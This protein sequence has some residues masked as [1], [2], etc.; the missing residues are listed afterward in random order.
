MTHDRSLLVLGWPEVRSALA[1][2]CRT[3]AGARA[4]EE[5]ILLVDPAEIRLAYQGVRELWELEL[6]GL[7]CPVGGVTDIGLD[8]EKAGRGLT[9]E[10]AD[11]RGIGG[12]LEALSV[13]RRWAESVAEEAPQVMMLAH[14]IEVDAELLARLHRSFDSQGELCGKEYPLLED[15]RR[16]KEALRARIRGTLDELLRDDGLGAMLQERF[17]TERNG[18]FVLPVKSSFRKGLGIVHG[19]SQSGETVYV[20]PG[21]VVELH[22]DLTEAEHALYR[23]E[24]R[25]LGELSDRVG[26][27]RGPI[28]RSLE[29]ATRLDLVCARVT[30]GRRIAGSLPAVQSEGILVVKDARHPLLALTPGGDTPRPAVGND[31]TLT[32]QHTGLILTG[33]NAGGKTVA[34][35]TLGLL[36]LLVRAAIPVP[37]AEGARIDVF[38]P[39]LADIGDQQSVAEGLSTFSAHV[40]A[41]SEAIA[42]ARPGAL[43]LIDEITAGTDPGQGAAIARAVVEALVDRGARVAVTTH[44]PELKALGAE[45]P[46]FV[47]AAAQFVNGQPTFRLETG[48]PGAS[49][50][51][52]I[53]RRMGMPEAVLDRAAMVMDES[54]RALARRLEALDG[55]RTAAREQADALKAERAGL[56]QRIDGVAAR[57]AVLSRR[58]EAAIDEERVRARARFREK[59]EEVRALV[60][61]LQANPEM[62]AANEA[63]RRV[64]DAAANLGDEAKAPEPVAIPTVAF[65]TGQRVRHARLG[66]VD[67]VEANGEKV[68]VSLKGMLSWVGA[69]DLAALG[70]VENRKEGRK[71][72]AVERSPKGEPPRPRD[73]GDGTSGVHVPVGPNTID[74]RGYRVEDAF[75][76]I[77]SFFDGHAARTSV[78][79]LLHGH[80]TGALKQGVR[81]WLPSSRYVRDFRPANAEEGGDAFTVVRLV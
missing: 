11:L 15:L 2:S 26:R 60:A 30:F 53:A 70:G 18:R 4:A 46:R 80:G 63:L 54:T 81:Q 51:M 10:C 44:F 57:E 59:E 79:F 6:G 35:K 9:L 75:P 48:A 37:T 77:E 32:A 36:A 61:A 52:A 58:I 31:L 38:D 56:Q 76:A 21:A 3:L 65:V 25:I 27:G 23:E 69:G 28:L 29:A 14:P 22:N 55:E 40:R 13:L 66:V 24:R 50:A 17:V 45:D 72:T 33:P 73:D 74:L 12:G 19:T 49:H 5:T 71:A 68:R 67:V 78:V 42:V 47:I 8:V 1:A 20:E 16:R 41:L 34:L 7:R 64:R 39:I 43:V 62:R